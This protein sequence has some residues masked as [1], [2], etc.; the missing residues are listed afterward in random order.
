MS[1]ST[2]APRLTIAGG[3]WIVLVGMA[4]IAA[5]LVWAFAG[6]V[7]GRSR[8]G[9]GRDPASYGFDLD[10]LRVDR[11]SLSGSG[12]PRDVF[13]PLDSPEVVDGRDV[14]ERN[15]EVR[16]KLAVNDDRV[17]GVVI[18]GEARAYP[19]RI[20]NAHEVVNDEIAGEPVAV[21]YGGL[22]DSALVFRRTIAGSVRR[23]GVSGL[24]VDSNLVM[25]DLDAPTPS[26][27]SQL[28]MRAISGP[29]AGTALEPVDGVSITTWAAWLAAHPGTTLALGDP[30][31]KRRYDSI[32][33]SRYFLER[34]LR[35]PVL[36]P[37]DE[38]SLGRDGLHLK[39]PM[40]AIRLGDA[41]K[42]VSIESLV[43]LLGR[44]GRGGV[45]ID[46]SLVRA[47]V[48]AD[49]AGAM[50][51]DPQGRPLLTVPCLWFAWHAFHPGATPAAVT[52]ESS[53][54]PEP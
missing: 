49:P 1:R 40:V 36:A 26:L 6:V 41:W 51:E 13:L 23:F 46:G 50:I 21:T 16:R 33:Y 45:R 3:G 27:W 5:L 7:Q 35:F 53:K 20:L 30:R 31:S 17:L 19:L 47:Q 2:P 8:M 44:Q 25:Y 38:Q 24:L 42:I 15:K 18:G 9:D 29:L 48:S 12:Q 52:A 39:S 34:S 11:R 43:S 28:G 54:T 10:G 4:L 37:P 22:C 32:S 14:F